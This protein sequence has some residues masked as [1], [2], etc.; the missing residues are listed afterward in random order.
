MSVKIKKVLSS[1]KRIEEKMEELQEQWQELS[2][3]KTELEN[4]EI[5]G[6]IRGAN[7]TTENLT[8]VIKAY[9]QTGDMPFA[10]SK[11]ENQ[12]EEI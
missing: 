12:H 1:M 11:E 9:H 2:K 7:I 3:E 4:L 8:E 6:L 10:I 5:I